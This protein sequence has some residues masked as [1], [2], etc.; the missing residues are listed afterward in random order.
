M[1][2]EVSQETLLTS[3]E[4]LYENISHALKISA[5]R[6]AREKNAIV[7]RQ[8]LSEL[9]AYVCR[10]SVQLRNHREQLKYEETVVY[11]L[12]ALRAGQ[13]SLLPSSTAGTSLGEELSRRYYE[14]I[15]ELL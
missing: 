3:G 10:R 4:I 5:T 6:M 12:N 15:D 2:K 13:T 7:T 1:E 14:S 8:R 9:V 11:E